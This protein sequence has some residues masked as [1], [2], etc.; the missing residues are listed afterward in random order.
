MTTK[1]SEVTLAVRYREKDETGAYRGGTM[2]I[3]ENA[4][5]MKWLAVVFA[6]FAFM[7]SFGIGNM[8]QANSTTEGIYMAFGVPHIYTAIVI[9]IIV[10]LVIWGGLNSIATVT[11]YLVP[12]MAIFYIL[13]AFTVLI[14]H[15][16]AIPAAFAMAVEGAFGDPRALPGALAGWAVKAAITRGIARGVFS[17]EAGLGSAP[18]VHCTARVDH[19]VRQGFYGLFEVFMDTIVIC[20][21]TATT[22]LVTGVLTGQPELTGAQLSLAAFSSTLGTAGTMILSLSLA[23]FALSTI[24]GWYWYGETAL[25][26]LCNGPALIKPF[27]IIWIILVVLGG[28][29]G[30]SVLANLWDLSDTLNGLMAVPNLIGLLLLSKELKRLTKDF[31]SKIKS[32]EL[33]K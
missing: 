15:I 7:A 8:V 14:Q 29:G 3:L 21:L 16:D 26:Y 30:A 10:G 33:R 32:G 13:G 23:L 19:P 28:W 25:V 18:M 1:F 2:Y 6:L 4:L 20:T 12:F 5:G 24:L 22:I 11:V 9:A 17:N 31:D 27:K